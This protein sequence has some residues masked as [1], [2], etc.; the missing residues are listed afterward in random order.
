MAQGA[1]GGRAQRRHVVVGP[2]ERGEVDVQ[3]QRAPG[4]IKPFRALAELTNTDAGVAEEFYALVVRLSKETL[5][6]ALGVSV[7]TASKD[8]TPFGL[9]CQRIVSEFNDD[10]T[11]FGKA[12]KQKPR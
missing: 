8:S 11:R 2:G 7:L 5:A 3:A 10:K 9:I 12:L 6:P 1:T 4:E